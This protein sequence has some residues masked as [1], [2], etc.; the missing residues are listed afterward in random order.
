[1]FQRIN[2]IKH[3]IV[4]HT[5][6]ALRYFL[7]EKPNGLDFTMRDTHLLREGN[8]LHG[9]SK[10][11]DKHLKK[12]F[13]TLQIIEEDCLLDIGCGKGGVLKE[14]AAYPFKR[15][16]GIDIDSRLIRIAQ[17]NFEVL[18][19]SDR[20]EV[21]TADALAYQEYGQFNIFFLFNPFGEDILRI[22]ID[23]LTKENVDKKRVFIIYHN[24][25]YHQ[26]IEDTGH[27]TKLKELYDPEKQYKTYIYGMQ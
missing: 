16:V 20:I 18:K 22:V 9:Y 13:E 1:M 3:R 2:K 23:R 27:C 21:T 26:V 17:N 15:I 11:D 7:L 25:V 14:A 10:T 24:P 6:Y 8:G 5:K 4:R 19:L 12:I